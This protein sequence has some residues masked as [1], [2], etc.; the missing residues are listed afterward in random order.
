[1]N[2]SQAK[3]LSYSAVP[4]LASAILM[5]SLI[6]CAST[7]TSS[8][9]IETYAVTP[10]NAWKPSTTSPQTANAALVVTPAPAKPALPANGS[11][12]PDSQLEALRKKIP[13]L[14]PVEIVTRFVMSPFGWRGS[15]KRG[16]NHAGADIKVPK[17]TPVVATADGVVKFSGAMS[18]YGNIVIIDHGDG[19]ESRY[20]HLSTRDVQVG[21]QVQQGEEIGKS[22]QTGRAT[23]PHV[24]Y[25][26]RENGVPVDP[27]FFLPAS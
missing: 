14:W 11:P 9:R 5:T 7:Q 18:G 2:L 8:A 13:S 19:Y 1:V 16:T 26:V 20:A 4:V 10:A 24:H 27:V 6:G 22:G 21:A 15:A 3:P 17:G 25:E 12:M 23:C